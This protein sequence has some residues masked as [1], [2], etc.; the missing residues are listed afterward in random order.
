MTSYATA[1]NKWSS[2][3]ESGARDVSL[4]M[5]ENADIAPGQHV[6]DVATG[7]GEPALTAAHRVG[8]G[9]YVLG[10]DISPEMLSFAQKRAKK[11]AL[12]NIKFEVMDANSLNI[13]AGI[14]DAVLC[15]WGLMFVDDLVATLCQLHSVLKS[16]GRISISVWASADEVPSLSLAARV[17]HDTLGLPAPNEGAKTAFALSDVCTLSKALKAAGFDQ[18]VV[19]RIPVNFNFTSPQDYVAYRREVSTPLVAAMAGHSE[20][21]QALAWQAV[22]RSVESYR[23]DTGAIHMRNWAFSVSATRNHR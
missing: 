17:V 7:V 23:N 22:A 8:P 14:F 2:L 19:K 18:V 4:S 15:R 10:I 5:L 9:G 13:P 21:D 11:A 3:I 20:N 1:W 12:Q 16:E 6:L